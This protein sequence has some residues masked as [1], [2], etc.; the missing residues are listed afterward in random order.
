MEFKIIV[1]AVPAV[2]VLLLLVKNTSKWSR[3]LQRYYVDQSNKL[4]GNSAGWDKPWRLALF[5]ALVIFF[6]IM[7]IVAVYV[8]VF[9]AV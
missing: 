9:S 2:V 8:A 7:A 3:S 4:Y 6:G 5:N 1:V